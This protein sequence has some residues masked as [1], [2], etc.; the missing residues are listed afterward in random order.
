MTIIILYVFISEIFVREK[1][2]TKKSLTST[3][4]ISASKINGLASITQYD[5]C[6][7]H[8]SIPIYYVGLWVRP[9]L[10]EQFISQGHHCDQYYINTIN[11]NKNKLYRIKS[12]LYLVIWAKACAKE[13]ESNTHNF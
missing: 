2:F 5:I 4:K 10:T 3:G 12:C 8:L 11:C 9:N 7:L 13:D 1:L 6:I